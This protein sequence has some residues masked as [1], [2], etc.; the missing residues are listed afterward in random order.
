MIEPFVQS[1]GISEVLDVY[2]TD[3]IPAKKTIRHKYKF[4][5]A[6][7]P[8][9]KTDGQEPRVSPVKCRLTLG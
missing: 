1:T 2:T 4:G 7:F 5:E 6:N 8:N 3:G 9:I